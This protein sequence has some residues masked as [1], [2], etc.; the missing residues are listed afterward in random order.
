MVLAGQQL[1]ESLLVVLHRS[2]GIQRIEETRRST[3]WHHQGTP[4]LDAALVSI[5]FLAGSERAGTPRP[6]SEIISRR[7]DY[8]GGCVSSG[9]E[10]ATSG[11]S[12]TTS[13]D[14][15]SNKQGHSERDGNGGRGRC[16]SRGQK[17]VV[18]GR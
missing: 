7:L 4:R 9:A 6:D 17:L 14:H 13:D 1:R 2:L 15:A 12:R 5:D 18:Q 16:R 3:T 8:A 10:S 11:G